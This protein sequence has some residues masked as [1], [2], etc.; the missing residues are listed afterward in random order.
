MKTKKIFF[1]L[2]LFVLLNYSSYIKAQ[3]VTID[4]NAFLENQTNYDSV[5]VLFERTAPSILKDSIYTD[6]NGYFSHDIA[7][8]IY[9]IT[10]SKNGYIDI[11]LTGN[12][13]YSN[14]TLQDTTLESIG[15]SGNLSGTLLPNTYKVGSNITVQS[16]D[17]LVISPGT[18]LKF[19]EKKT[20]VINGLLIS[21]GNAIDSI[22]F[23]SYNPTQYWSGI[24]FKT[25][26]ANTKMSFCLVEKSD[27][28]GIRIYNSSPNFHNIC[29]KNNKYKPSGN[30]GDDGGGGIYFYN[31]YSQIDSSVISG[32]KC[33]AGGGVYCKSGH[34]RI[35]NT[36]IKNNSC[37]YIAGGIYVNYCASLSMLNP[38]ITDN[39]S[40][41]TNNTDADGIY[42][43][44]YLSGYPD[45]YLEITNG[46]IT[47]NQGEGISGYY[48][49]INIK[50]STISNNY[51]TGINAGL[52]LTIANSIIT[53]NQVYGIS[54]NGHISYCDLYN[55]TSGNFSSSDQWLGTNVTVNMNGDSC[56]P[57]Y[58]LQK[59]PI[60]VNTTNKDFHLQANSPCIDAGANDSVNCFTDL[61]IYK[62]I[63]DGNLDGDTIVDMGAYEYGSSSPEVSIPNYNRMENALMLYPNPASNKI[64]LDIQ[65]S[66]ALQNSFITVYNINGQ[67][68]MQQ[69]L[70][71]PQ[72][73][74]DISKLE[75][76]FYFI[77]LSNDANTSMSKFIKN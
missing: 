25:A 15:L 69:P 9:N 2:F 53:N 31:S 36:I 1:T 6:N 7:T 20:F 44:S 42:C 72:T 21:E 43:G 18:I 19:K 63:F 77:K 35:N 74:I 59:D 47:N 48:F 62:R 58:N 26:N 38:I 50:N 5:K 37:F 4:G 28:S 10:Y 73:E 68:L 46:L 12:S 52:K 8:G 29:I 70:I 16:G 57:Y 45:P 14:T 51:K 11:L 27:S 66:K 39:Y 32:N 64:T 41:S 33:D 65:Q 55:N 13:L 30:I 23:T 3:T 40:Y 61:D 60:Y 67:L 76:G 22:K 49:K 17:T 71:E 56:D 34:T 75:K 24:K 54:S